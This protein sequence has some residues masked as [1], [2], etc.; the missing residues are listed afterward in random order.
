MRPVRQYAVLGSVP[1][2]LGAT[3]VGGW[4]GEPD[5]DERAD[6]RGGSCGVVGAM[7][8]AVVDVVGAIVVVELVDVVVDE[9]VGAAAMRRV[10]PERSWPVPHAGSPVTASRTATA[11]RITDQRR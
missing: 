7:G 3:D 2:G 10:S 6:G 8:A 1:V 11:R 9:G 5:R 4:T